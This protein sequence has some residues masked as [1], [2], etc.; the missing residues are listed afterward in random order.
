MWLILWAIVALF[1]AY[2]LGYID[3]SEYERKTILERMRRWE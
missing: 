1:L 2:W 3:G